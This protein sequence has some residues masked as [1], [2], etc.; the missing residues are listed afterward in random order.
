MCHFSLPFYNYYV[1]IIF[2]YIVK[3][4]YLYMSTKTSTSKVKKL[5]FSILNMDHYYIIIPLCIISAMFVFGAFTGKWPWE[6]NPFNSFALQADSWLHGRLDLGMNY[7]YLELAIFNEK[8]YVSFPP[9]PSYILLPFALFM[10]S[11]TP[12][13]LISCAM[14]LVGSIYAYKLCK[15]LLNTQK[16]S[17]ISFVF[18]VLIYLGSNTL[19]FISNGWVWFIAQ[20]FSFGLTL[21]SLYYAVKGCPGRSLT[22]WAC[23]VGCRPFQFIYLPVLI[24]LMIK[25][26]R[27]TDADFT[28]IGILKKQWYKCIPCGLIGL[29]Y[30]ILNYAR[31]GNILEFGHNYLPEFTRIETGQFDLSY[32]AVNLS[33]MFRLPLINTDTANTGLI[34]NALNFFN[35][36]GVAFYIVNPIFILFLITLIYK[37]FVKDREHLGLCILIFVL[38]CLNIVFLCMHRT[39]GGWHFGN[40]YTCDMLPFIL[41][42]I[43]ISMPKNEKFMFLPRL[44]FIFGFALNLVGTVAS[45]NYWI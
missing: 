2:S 26:W 9:F 28:I 39:L 33:R 6:N 32:L 35:C 11:N 16:S 1:R 29:S 40:R 30:C 18:T 13:N 14:T 5:W 34:N 20:N 17:T 10:G 7:E 25:K 4:E 15:E 23:A 12:D 41:T 45:Y 22:F 3:G 36:D 31:F 19:F 37:C 24:W 44:V 21:M 38:G 42:G 27:K 8:Y 43:I